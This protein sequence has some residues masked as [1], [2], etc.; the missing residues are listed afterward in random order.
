[1]AITKKDREDFVGGVAR[2]SL[3]YLASQE[4]TPEKWVALLTGQSPLFR[5]SVFWDGHSAPPVG[6]SGTAPAEWLALVSD[7][8]ALHRSYNPDTD[9]LTFEEAGLLLI[10]P[11]LEPRISGDIAKWPWLPSCLGSQPPEAGI[12]GFFL[13]EFDPDDP[14]HV[15]LHMGNSLSPESPFREPSTRARELISLLDDALSRNPSATR[16]SS[17]SWLSCFEPFQRFFPPQWVHSAVASPP[18]YTYDW[19]GQFV[20]RRGAFHRANGDHL[21]STG[22]FPYPSVTC[23]AP[24]ESVRSHLTSCFGLL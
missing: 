1:M 13:Y 20:T 14:N 8:A 15:I 9:T 6:N 3:W 11:H 7:V 24:I 17:T 18:G 4:P 10:W 21:R 22:Q 23:T 19:W 5:L 2:L 12:F 16:I